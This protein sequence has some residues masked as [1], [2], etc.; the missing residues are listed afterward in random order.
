MWNLYNGMPLVSV[1]LSVTCENSFPRY[2][3]FLLLHEATHCYVVKIKI[4]YKRIAE[5]SYSEIPII[6]R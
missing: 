3:S 2:C 5:V 6:Q 1:I 4:T